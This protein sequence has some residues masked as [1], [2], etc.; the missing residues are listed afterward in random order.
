M[1]CILFEIADR[2]YFITPSVFSLQDVK[3]VKT[4]PFRNG[5]FLYR[6]HSV[7]V[8]SVAEREG[9]EGKGRDRIDM[10]IINLIILVLIPFDYRTSGV[11]FPNFKSSIIEL[12][13]FGFRTS[14]RENP[15]VVKSNTGG[16]CTRSKVLDI[17]YIRSA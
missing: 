16:S 10:T 5:V 1:P 7:P 12:I 14:D 8:F 13:G 6:F 17:D 4:I 9:K 3:S 15:Y 2:G 11:R